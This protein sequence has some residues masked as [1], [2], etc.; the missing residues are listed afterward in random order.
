MDF[1][2]KQLQVFVAVVT[3]GSTM[4]ASRAL[5]KS[6]PAVSSAIAELETHLGSQLFDRWKKRMV[7]NERGRALLPMARLLLANARDLGQMFGAGKNQVSGTLRLGASLTLANY[8]MPD[9]L[10]EFVAVYPH[11]KMDVVC[12]NKVG[13]IAQ[14]EDFSIDIGV[15]AGQCS[16]PD[17]A[18]RPWLTDEL[19]VFAAASHPLARKPR[20]TTADLAGSQWILR[21]EGSGTLEVFHNA[22]PAGTRPLRII[23]EFDNLESIKRSVEHG[24]AL[25]CLSRMAVKREV[26]AGLLKILPTPYLDLR[27]DY[28][29]LVHQ[30]RHQSALLS[31]FLSYCSIGGK[32]PVV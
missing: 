26:E 13:I 7:L 18:S 22:L 5:S 19:C 20:V 8:V 3:R 24:K 17:V 32:P 11:V 25:S 28:Y 6:Q 1:T 15:I 23:M 2:L 31:A 30:K 9:T 16:K 4:A 14:I 12:R 10:S 29:F 27:R 21:E